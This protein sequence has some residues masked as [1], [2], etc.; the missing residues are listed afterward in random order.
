MVLVKLVRNRGADT[1]DIRVM[2]EAIRS[3]NLELV[4]WLE[5]QGVVGR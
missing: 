3:G 5:F 4:K 2:I 1:Y